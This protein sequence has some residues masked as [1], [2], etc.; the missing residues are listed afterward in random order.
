[1]DAKI[2]CIYVYVFAHYLETFFLFQ[3]IKTEVNGIVQRT[4]RQCTYR[5]MAIYDAIMYT[6]D[7]MP[8]L[9]RSAR[10]SLIVETMVTT[11]TDASST[12]I[13]KVSPSP[14]PKQYR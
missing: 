13:S 1:M 2:K 6:T 3:E 14:C 9:D 11:H 4:V 5:S 12:L 7:N 10:G 8:T